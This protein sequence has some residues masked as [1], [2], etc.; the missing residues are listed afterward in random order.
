MTHPCLSI[1]LTSTVLQ[2]L[3]EVQY[4]RRLVTDLDAKCTEIL[5]RNYEKQ[6][7]TKEGTHKQRQLAIFFSFFFFFF[8]Y[9]F[10]FFFQRN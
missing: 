9:L 4:C 2:A 1:T 8:L 5:E 3:D 10:I 7:C 6:G